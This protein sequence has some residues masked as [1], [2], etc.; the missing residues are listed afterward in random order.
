MYL[1]YTVG[2][3]THT[4]TH[5]HTLLHTPHHAVMNNRIIHFTSLS[6]YSVWGEPRDFPLEADDYFTDFISCGR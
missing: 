3:I 5:T 6:V 4:H 2:Y 1:Y